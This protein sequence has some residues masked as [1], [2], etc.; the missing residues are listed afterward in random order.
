MSI[1]TADLTCQQEK[2]LPHTTEREPVEYQRSTMVTNRS[3]IYPHGFEKWHRK[4]SIQNRQ[5]NS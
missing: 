5:G 3:R 4:T 1:S 2:E